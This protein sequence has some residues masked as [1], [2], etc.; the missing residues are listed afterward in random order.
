MS[1]MAIRSNFKVLRAQLE[2]RL[3]RRIS[4][5]EISEQA[6]IP[7]AT[8]IRFANNDVSSVSYKTLDKL[9]GYF[10]AGGLDCEVGDLI[11]SVPD[12]SVA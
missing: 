10:R 3:G 1:Q 12:E 7:E 11:V 6:Q 2:A 8:L 5:K 4:Y 9:Y